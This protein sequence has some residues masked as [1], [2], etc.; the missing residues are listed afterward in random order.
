MVSLCVVSPPTGGRALM[1]GPMSLRAGQDPQFHDC[2]GA[3]VDIVFEDGIALV[4]SSKTY[5]K[6][7][8]MPCWRHVLHL[9]QCTPSRPHALRL[10]H[11]VCSM[12]SYGC[13]FNQLSLSACL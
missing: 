8:A 12:M 5:A 6:P 1:L 2:L 11:L 10:R 7:A 4:L 3:R 9:L 13:R